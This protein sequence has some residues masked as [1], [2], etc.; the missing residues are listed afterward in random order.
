MEK[1]YEQKYHELEREQWWFKS[2]RDMVLR[3]VRQFPSQRVLDIG[4]SS[5]LL[6]ENLLELGVQPEN[7]YGVDISPEAIEKCRQKGFQNCYVMDGAAIDFPKGSFDLLI[8]SDCLE[9]IENDRKALQNW[10][11]L[12]RPGGVLICFVPAY[13]SLWSEHDVVNHHFRRYTKEEL[14]TKM[15]AAKFNVTESGYWNFF[16]FLPVYAFRMLKNAIGKF[17][18]ERTPTEDLQ[19]T[20][21]LVNSMLSILLKV[22]NSLLEKGKIHYPFGVS[23]FCIAKK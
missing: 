16:L 4:C 2:R 8:A 10:Y 7:L 14:Q 5:G 15:Q 21:S 3:Y 18:K 1:A 12:L 23:T 6:L 20:N 9:H 13:M 17:Y 11:D 19:P 22:E